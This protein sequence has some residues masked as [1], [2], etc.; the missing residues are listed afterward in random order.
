MAVLSEIWALVT[1]A[2]FLSLV[3]V[4][5]MLSSTSTAA[6]QTTYNR[7]ELA[8]L[9]GKAFSHSEYYNLV[10]PSDH[11]AFVGGLWDE[12][13]DLE[14]A[15]MRK[16]GL[17]RNSSIIDVGCGALRGGVKMVGF[18]D[19]GRYYGIDLNPHLLELGLKDEIAPLG[20]SSKLD[21]SHLHA[22]ADFDVGFFGVVFDFA[23][24][25]SVWTHLPL[26]A[27][28]TSMQRV[29]AALE[30]TRGRF[31][32]TYY[33]CPEEHPLSKTIIQYQRGME[34]IVSQGHRDWFHHRRSDL[35]HLAAQAGL[36]MRYVGNWGHPRDQLMLEFRIDPTLAT[37]PPI[38]T[39]RRLLQ[40][41]A[42]ATAS[43][44]SSSA[45]ASSATAAAAPAAAS[46]SVSSASA[47]SSARPPSV[48]CPAVKYPRTLRNVLPDEG[49]R[50]H[51][52][53][54]YYEHVHGGK[55]PYVYYN[56]LHR[57]GANRSDARSWT[58]L[59]KVHHHAPP[60]IHH[61]ASP[62][63]AMHT[64]SIAPSLLDVCTPCTPSL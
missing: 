20:L 63:T 15:F 45:A 13:G 8:Q 24:S 4:M 56:L 36:S 5:M 41:E 42:T 51:L 43:A 26:S 39:E 14:L 12:I 48:E 7:S 23:L 59:D 53:R 46:V 25:V 6:A 49:D 62:C 40:R 57:L 21:R 10:K 54:L 32:A 30:P 1:L 2:S 50:K 28:A 33:E 3:G 11:R 16:M 29:A 27:V 64:I 37:T 35:H 22:T 58:A 55:S 61:H 17:A 52:S 38:H 34:R 18:L 47:P 31:Y 44:A 19:P 9:N 60:P